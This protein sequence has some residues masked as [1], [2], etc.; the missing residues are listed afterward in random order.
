MTAKSSYGEGVVWN[1][2]D[3]AEFSAGPGKKIQRVAH[4]ASQEEMEE[5][6]G[7][8][9]FKPETLTVPFGSSYRVGAL[10]KVS[11]LTFSTANGSMAKDRISTSKK[12]AF[13][14]ADA[15]SAAFCVV[16]GV[17]LENLTTTPFESKAPLTAEF[18]NIN[19]S[20]NHYFAAGS[21]QNDRTVRFNVTPGGAA[22]AGFSRE[23]DGAYLAHTKDH[24]GLDKSSLKGTYGALGKNKSWVLE[25]A[26]HVGLL[27]ENKLGVDENHD[28]LIYDGPV[29]DID[30]AADKTLELQADHVAFSDL[31]LDKL[32]FNLKVPTTT[33]FNETTGKHETKQPTFYDVIKNASRTFPDKPVKA[34]QLENYAALEKQFDNKFVWI[35]G[36]KKVTFYH[37]LPKYEVVDQ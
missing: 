1:D 31:S 33:V 7:V 34:D 3:T 24:P 18:P 6:I 30:K 9:S 26:P 23:V 19:A 28:V 11:S 25:N 17:T 27:D 13:F 15:K 8:D 35:G 14:G 10:K 20:K 32:T 22:P 12:S 36:D 2:D 29:E 21:N 16:T 5:R 4:D 37:S